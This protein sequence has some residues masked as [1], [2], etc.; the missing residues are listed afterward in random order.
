MGWEF[1]V[2]IS[3]NERRQ[4]KV[5]VGLQLNLLARD[6]AN[7]GEVVVLEIIILLV[8]V[9]TRARHRLRGQT[10]IAKEG[11]GWSGDLRVGAAHA[12]SGHAGIDA[13][14][15]ETVRTRE[16]GRK[17]VALVVL[18]RCC[19]LTVCGLLSVTQVCGKTV[20]LLFAATRLQIYELHLSLKA[21][22]LLFEIF[23]LKL[24]LL[25]L[26]NVSA[27]HAQLSSVLTSN[28]VTRVTVACVE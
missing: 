25:E 11:G 21:S 2:D 6:R 23:V 14:H 20:N 28:N 26:K 4:D 9:A 13:R 10:T 18:G 1:G 19:G 3:C 24:L 12:R 7:G 17:A 27:G 8:R 5:K 22:A 15:A 16:G